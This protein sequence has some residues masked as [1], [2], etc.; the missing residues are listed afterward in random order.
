MGG[1]GGGDNPEVPTILP[2]TYYKELRSVV[3]SLLLNNFILGEIKNFTFT[4]M[5]SSLGGGNLE[6]TPVSES[7][8]SL[9]HLPSQI[10]QTEAPGSGFTINK[11]SSDDNL[12]TIFKKKFS[13]LSYLYQT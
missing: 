3:T 6:F 8:T 2:T 9:G 7:E 11:V 10:T 4:L 1:G 13:L 5:S 12:P